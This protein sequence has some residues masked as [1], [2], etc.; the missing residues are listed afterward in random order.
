MAPKNGFIAPYIRFPW[1]SERALIG[2][3]VSIYKVDGGF[4]LEVDNKEFKP[5]EHQTK[6]ITSHKL[7]NKQL[8]PKSTQDGTTHEQINDSKYLQ[9]GVKKAIGECPR[10]DLNRRQPDLQSGALPG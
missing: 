3:P 7:E 10:P 8:T 9:N 1:N 4:Y 6:S 2:K 5:S